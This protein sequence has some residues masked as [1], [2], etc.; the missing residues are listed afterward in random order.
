[1]RCIKGAMQDSVTRLQR[2]FACAWPCGLQ[3]TLVALRPKTA[4]LWDCSQMH[5]PL[6]I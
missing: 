3:T 5:V 2:N 1:M 6:D 4:C